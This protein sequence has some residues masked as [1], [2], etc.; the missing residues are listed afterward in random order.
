MSGD[1]PV[2]AT[3]PTRLYAV[4]NTGVFYV[5]GPTPYVP[6]TANKH[7]LAVR[8]SNGAYTHTDLVTVRIA[9]ASPPVLTL[10]ETPAQRASAHAAITPG[11]IVISAT[12]PHGLAVSFSITGQTD[13]SGAKP[14]FIAGQSYANGLAKAVI[15]V[16]PDAPISSATDT[17]TIT[18]TDTQ[19]LQTVQDI[20]F[21]PDLIVTDGTGAEPQAAAGL[22]S[23]WNRPLYDHLWPGL[24]LG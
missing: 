23:V 21:N 16:H 1:P 13:A 4:S 24:H 9:D 3:D 10:T 8:V 18:A 22:A 19:G 5:N 7:I 11:S 15:F 2:S 17:L 14:Y 20:V 6:N 12:D